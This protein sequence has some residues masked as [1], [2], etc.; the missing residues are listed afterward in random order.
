MR[1]AALAD[2]VHLEIVDTLE[3]LATV[4]RHRERLTMTLLFGCLQ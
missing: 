4:K 1:I 3:E 2:D